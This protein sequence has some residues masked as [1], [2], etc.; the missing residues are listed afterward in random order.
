MEIAINNSAKPWTRSRCLRI[1]AWSGVGLLATAFAPAAALAVGQPIE[2]RV[3]YLD[4]GTGSLIIQAVV[5][6]LAGAA[7]VITSYWQKIKKFFGRN[8]RN[9]EPSDTASSDD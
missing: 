7:V 3:A 1:A 6:V 4:P 2:I 9:S 8:S 5:A